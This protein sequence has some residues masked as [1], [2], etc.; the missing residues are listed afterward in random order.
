M[1]VPLHHGV[2]AWKA[3][4]FQQHQCPCFCLLFAKTHVDA[5]A[6][7]HLVSY[8]K[9][10]VQGS[11]GILE[12]HSEPVPS[13]LVQLLLSQFQKVP[14]FK[15]PPA[16]RNLA[17]TS[18]KPH[19][20]QG[21]DTFPTAGFPHDTDHLTWIHI[22]IHMV[23]ADIFS[24]IPGKCNFQI[25]DFQDMRHNISS[26]L[27]RT[28]NFLLPAPGIPLPSAGY[29]LMGTGYSSSVHLNQEYPESVTPPGIQ[30]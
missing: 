14:S 5:D 15:H 16:G 11:Q 20:G 10:R 24:S 26:F 3:H 9:H 18:Q 27:L 7:R 28:V 8:C 22:E 1:G 25:R 13:D 2:G 30:S 19:N 23:Y 4:P 17:A 12:Y 29:S 6:L 21:G